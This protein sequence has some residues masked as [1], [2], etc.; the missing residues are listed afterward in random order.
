MQVCGRKARGPENL[1]I[2]HEQLTNRGLSISTTHNDCTIDTIDTDND[3]T[4]DDS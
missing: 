4:I 1:P 3:Y 2:N